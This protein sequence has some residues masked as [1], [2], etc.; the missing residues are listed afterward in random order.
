MND[1]RYRWRLEEC[2][3]YVSSGYGRANPAPTRGADL[4]E[5]HLRGFIP[6]PRI[7]GR[8]PGRLGWRPIT[9]GVGS[10]ESD[11]APEDLTQGKTEEPEQPSS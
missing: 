7:S 5:G 2:K 4:G 9:G 3:P 10:A 1:E 8:A 6:S 11:I